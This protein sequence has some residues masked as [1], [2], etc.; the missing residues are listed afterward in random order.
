MPVLHCRLFDGLALR[1]ASHDPFIHVHSSSR[2]DSHKSLQLI[3]S[4][5]FF[6]FLLPEWFHGCELIFRVIQTC[7][8]P[9]SQGKLVKYFSRQLSCK[10]KV[11]LEERSAELEDFPRLGHWFRIVNLRKEV[12]EVWT[13]QRK[14][15]VVCKTS[16]QNDIHKPY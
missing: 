8:P 3:N 7:F 6:H 1:S 13:P 5:C 14:L 12:T 9:L 10:C 15:I 16:K 2:D 11:A 4:V